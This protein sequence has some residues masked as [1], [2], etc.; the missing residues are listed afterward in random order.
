LGDQNLI[1]IRNENIDFTMYNIQRV[2]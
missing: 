2:K 1:C